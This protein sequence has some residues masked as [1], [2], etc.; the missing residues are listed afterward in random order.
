VTVFT[1]LVAAYDAPTASGAAGT[2]TIEMQ[3]K[4]AE[5]GLRTLEVPIRQ[6]RRLGRSKI[7]GTL[8]GGTRAGARMLAVIVTLWWTRRVRA[9]QDAR[10]RG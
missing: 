10:A 3:V 5:A 1:P 4:A 8:V 6:R 7:S 9:R 2:W